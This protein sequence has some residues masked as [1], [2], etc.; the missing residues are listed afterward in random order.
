MCLNVRWLSFQYFFAANLSLVVSLFCLC[1][2][3]SICVVAGFQGSTDASLH[4]GLLLAQCL[5]FHETPQ[6]SHIQCY[7]LVLLV[8]FP[9][10]SCC[11][12]SCNFT[13]KPYS[14]NRFHNFSFV[15]RIK[16]HIITWIIDHQ[17]VK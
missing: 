1:L 7:G 5:I 9:Q 4:K 13:Q 15:L 14:Q 3:V 10:S 11:F 2:T 12:Y 6:L 17:F 8:Q 16:Y